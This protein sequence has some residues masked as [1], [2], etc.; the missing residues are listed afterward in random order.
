MTVVNFKSIRPVPSAGDFCDIVLSKTQRKTPTLVH[1]GYA[2]G[3]I[4]AFYMRKVKYT[5]EAFD[6]KLGW[7]LDDF[8]TLDDQHPFVA[9][10]CNVLYDRDHYKLALGQLNIC[11]Q[12]IGTIAKDYVRLLKYGDTLYRCKQLKRAALGRMATLMRKHK[13]SL[14]YLEEVRKHLSRL[15]AIDP[16]TRTLLITGYPNVGKSSFMNKVTRADVEVQPYAFTTQSLFVG[17]MDH[18]YLRW[19]VIDTPG[20]LDKP[21]EE[22]NTIE[23]QSITA[24]AHLQCCVLYFVDLSEQCGWTL[25]QQA[26]LFDNI[27]PLFANKP[28]VV[29]ANKIDVAPLEQ[30]SKQHRALLDKMVKESGASLLPMSAAAGLGVAE[31]KARACELLLE[32]RVELKTKSKKLDSV[33]SRLTVAQPQQRDSKPR[34]AF[35]PEGV[36][37]LRKLRAEAAARAE[38]KR[39]ARGED[40]MS[41]G[42]EGEEEGDDEALRLRPKRKTER[43]LMWENGGPGVYSADYRKY[44]LLRNDEHKFDAVPEIMDGKNIA[45]FVDPDIMERL[46]ELEREEEER[47][48]RENAEIEAADEAESDLD[49]EEKAF[50]AKIRSKKKIIVERH[51]EDKGKNRP[52]LPKKHRP[53]SGEQAAERLERDGYETAKFKDTVEEQGRGRKR[54]RDHQSEAEQE[55]ERGRGRGRSLAADTQATPKR[56]KSLDV[57]RKELA[58]RSDSKERANSK[59]RSESRIARSQSREHSGLHTPA[60]KI[61]ANKKMKRAQ[62]LIQR[63]GKAGEADRVTMNRMPKHLFAGKRSGQKTASHR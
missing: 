30:L 32:Q 54:Q 57:A 49:E 1:Q 59:A 4:R 55:E 33:L 6:E 10:L 47:A 20:I 24:L 42:E 63:D 52:T 51:R 9:D 21:L 39:A 16:N 23:M 34:P 53:L 2:I 14:G 46:E 25:E 36:E 5:H 18:Q 15:P 56:A 60:R 37:A 44:Y 7:I 48:A 28:L 41:D 17:H 13:S 27:R 50:V 58:S 62:L 40:A 38:A 43:D 31:V 45:D 3:R 19:Q 29:V 22:R 61:A 12:L 26:A 8:P 35:I 11:R